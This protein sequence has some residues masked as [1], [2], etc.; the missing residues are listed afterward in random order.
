[1]NVS[2]SWGVFGLSFVVYLCSHVLSIFSSLLLFLRRC[3][4]S[5]FLVFSFLVYSCASF[6]VILRL[7]CFCFFLISVSCVLLSPF[8]ALRSRFH[9]STPLCSTCRFLSLLISF[10]HSTCVQPDCLPVCCG[11]L[12]SLFLSFPA[13]FY[14]VPVPAIKTS[15]CFCSFQTFFFPSVKYF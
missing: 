6:P 11:T 7:L 3:H 1:M 5:E 4:I 8:S 10:I 9:A 14:S 12:T 2:R 15:F 13:V